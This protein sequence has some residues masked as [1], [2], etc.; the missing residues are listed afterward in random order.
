MPGT[1]CIGRNSLSPNGDILSD[2]HAEIMCRRGFIRYLYDQMSAHING[3]ESTIFSF[4]KE[5]SKFHWSPDVSFHLVTTHSPCGDAS[6]FPLDGETNLTDGATD[7]TEVPAKKRKVEEST[8]DDDSIGE[9][10]GG[11]QNFTGA[12]II[13]S[14]SDVVQDW[15]VQSMGAVRTKPGRG[16]PTLSMSCSDKLAKW[17]VLGIQGALLYRWLDRPI[18]LDSIIFC[19][20]SNANVAAMKRAIVNRFDSREFK[21]FPNFLRKIPH[22]C[23][24]DSV[25][26]DFEKDA[27][28]EPCPSSIVWCRVHKKEHEVCVA[29]KRQGITKKKANTRSARLLIAKI[30]LF[31]LYIELIEELQNMNLIDSSSEDIRQMK[32]HDVK[33]LSTEYQSQWRE[34]KQKMFG[35]WSEKPKANNSFVID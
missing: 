7:L 26:F 22:I 34:I 25:R 20:T 28:L 8:N 15:M 9:A 1:K 6:I 17:N 3:N 32:Y 24:C 11:G 16:D 31:R 18:Y 13:P 30:E 14:T 2:C 35:V 27:R 12:K 19:T 33:C 5:T 23:S 4:S 29:G 10:V 21:F